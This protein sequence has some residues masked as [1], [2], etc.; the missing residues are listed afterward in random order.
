[1]ERMT[2]QDLTTFLWPDELGWTQDFGALAVLDGRGLFDPDGRLRIE[3][4]RAAI[5]SR[6]HLVPRFRQVPYVPR[7]GLGRPLWVDD[8]SF[9]LADHIRVEPLT[10]PGGEEQV[11]SAA[12]NVRRRPLDRSRP[13]WEMV[14]FPGLAEQRVGLFLR[15]NHAVADGVAAVS[16]LSALLGPGSEQT[17]VP[18]Q[19]WTPRQRPLDAELRRDVRHERRRTLTS[20]WLM[21]VRPIRTMRSLGSAWPATRQSLRDWGAPRTSLNRRIGP[22]RVMALVRT[23][24]A[25]VVTA[26]HRHS[27]T[28]ND[29]LL[30]AVASGIGALLRARG[31]PAEGVVMKAVLPVSLH[32]P[33]SEL[34]AGN[35]LGQMVVPLP[36]GPSAA[37]E[38][39]QWIAR[40]TAARKGVGPPGWAPIPSGGVVQR[41]FLAYMARQRRA[42]TFV[43]NVPGPRERLH[44]AGM[45]VLRIFPVVPLAGNVTLGVGALSYAG[46]L[47]ITA[48]GDRVQCPDIGLFTDEVR[49]TLAALGVSVLR[50][51]L[52]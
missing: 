31:E 1:M 37:D 30:T 14:M 51:A 26:A 42:N 44:L 32:D 40:Q 13:L 35:R 48:V 33:Q 8:Q 22:D 20:A 52:S 6:L 46:Q 43:S 29:V 7:R 49:N 27:A 50:P 47:N 11:L 21:L 15:V 9:T 2:A 28:V 34:T 12:E 16:M 23:D 5:A 38:R 24:L 18:E 39:L 10:P 36:V 4:V 41:L 17:S 3:T 25:T 19:Q 45:P